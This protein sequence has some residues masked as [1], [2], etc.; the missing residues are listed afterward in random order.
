[1]T[2]LLLGADGQLGQ[3][4]RQQPQWQHFTVIAQSHR[5]LDIT[6]T[7]AL[8]QQ[9]EQHQPKVVINCAA[10]TN[11]ALA[12]QQAERCYAVN[13]HAVVQLAQLCRKH[14]SLLL[15]FSTDYVFNGNSQH[16]YTETDTPD[17]LNVYGHSKWLAEQAVQQHCHKYLLIRTSWLFGEHGQNFYRTMLK[18]ASQQTDIRVVD[19]QFGCPTYAGHL[20]AILLQLLQQ[21]QQQGA[22]EYGLYHLAGQPAVSW[23]QF[24]EAIFSARQL[25][26][27][28]L[29]VSTA[30]FAASVQR[31]A[32]SAL[33]CGL[34]SNTFA[35]TMPSWQQALQYLA[36]EDK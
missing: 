28:V 8:A 31:P 27:H 15:Q 13:T 3:A 24:A 2:I 21:Y 26:P 25:A 10:Y 14:D 17:A 16:A 36:A 34:F 12:E 4:L 23:F 18:K 29:P 22:L 6:D 9:F 32:N 30:D 5:Q 19:D 35:V 20:A 11:V 7:Q 1:M 33:N